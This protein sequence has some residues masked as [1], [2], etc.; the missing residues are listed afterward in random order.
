MD[1]GAGKRGCCSWV[2][3]DFWTADCGDE[4]ESVVGCVS[5]GRVAMDG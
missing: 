1:S 3:G 5:E 2:D 4:G